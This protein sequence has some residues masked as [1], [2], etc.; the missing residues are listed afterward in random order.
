MNTNSIEHPGETETAITDRIR[1]A[2]ELVQAVERIWRDAAS[3][4]E[5]LGRAR[6]AV[7]DADV[8]GETLGD[9]R[10]LVTVAHAAAFDLTQ[11]TAPLYQATDPIPF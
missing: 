5:C 10:R 9:L 11:A 3:A 1:H 7:D 2:A 6:E 8:A 4:V